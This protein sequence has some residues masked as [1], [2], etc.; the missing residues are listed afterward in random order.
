MMIRKIVENVYNVGAIDWDRVIFDELIST[1]QGTTYNAYIVIG[2][3]KTALID[4]VEPEFYEELKRNLDDLGITKIDYVISNHAEQDHSGALP[5][6]IRDF[7]ETK[8][9][10]NSKCKNLE[11][12]LLHI[13]D[14]KFITIKDGD[15]VS[16]GDL[17]LKFV[18]TPWVHWPET[19]TTFLV[20]RKIAFTCDFFGS[21]AATSH[22]FAEQYDRIYHEAKRYYAEIMMPFRHLIRK[23]IEKIENLHPEIIAPSHGPAYSDPEFIIKAY[24]E[25]AMESTKN[26]VLIGYVSMHGSTKEIVKYLV[27]ALQ[28]T[29]VEVR[30]RNLVSSDMGEFAMDLVDATTVLIATPTVLSGPHPAAVYAAYL[31]NALKPKAQIFGVIGSY[32][33]GGR[34]VD[35]IKSI[36]STLKV[37]FLEPVIIEGAPKDDDFKKLDD[38]AKMIADEHRNLGVMQ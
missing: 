17:T 2:K 4:T 24:K 7:P 20:E 21:H 25:W 16:L 5:M 38:F 1:P 9:I 3:E 11:K 10:T 15:T 34:T 32:G 27:H 33:W 18:F 8:I 37:K 29:G 28:K 6:I 14:E 31:I 35:I 12:A 23:N 22:T 13:P 19:M 30:V 36:I 26:M